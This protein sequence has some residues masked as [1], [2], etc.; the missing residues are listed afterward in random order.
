MIILEVAERDGGIA[1][2]WIFFVKLLVL[3]NL[4]SHHCI[5]IK[6]NIETFTV[7]GQIL[8]AAKSEKIYFVQ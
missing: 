3:H 7:G 4:R 1:Q 5:L 2:T 8:A 6:Y